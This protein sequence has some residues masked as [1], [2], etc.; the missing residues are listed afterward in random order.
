MENKK[1][2][3]F[4]EISKEFK[5]FI[6]DLQLWVYYSKTP[7]AQ[8]E[9]FFKY[10]KEHLDKEYMLAAYMGYDSIL[11]FGNKQEIKQELNRFLLD[12]LKHRY[13]G[14]HYMTK[15]YNIDK[16]KESFWECEIIE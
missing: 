10:V 14:T 2:K 9:D 7:L 13:E 12:H 5:K 16:D 3:N 15:I 11:F 1:L 8:S 4:K 6:V